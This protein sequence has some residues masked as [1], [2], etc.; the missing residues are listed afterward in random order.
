VG[1]AG[2]DGVLD[3]RTFLVR[4]SEALSGE[5]EHPVRTVKRPP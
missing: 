5:D 3:D 1:D 2:S 4:L